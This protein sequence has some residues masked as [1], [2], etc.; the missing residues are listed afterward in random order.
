MGTYSLSGSNYTLTLTGGNFT[1]ATEEVE[2]ETEFDFEEIENGTWS[3]SGNTL[4]LNS[5]D[6]STIVFKN[7]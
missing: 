6:G 3:R 7:G 4:T 5:D 1:S 2:T